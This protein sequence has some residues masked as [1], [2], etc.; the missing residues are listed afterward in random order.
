MAGRMLRPLCH[1]LGVT[2]APELPAVLQ[3]RPPPRFRPSPPPPPPYRGIEDPPEA[4][5]LP[6][7]RPRNPFNRVWYV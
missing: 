2:A 3:L 4:P 6:T 7:G 5:P 1:I